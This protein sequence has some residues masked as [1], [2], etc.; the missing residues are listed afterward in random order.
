MLFFMIKYV[1]SDMLDTLLDN[2][3][4]CDSVFVTMTRVPN[5]CHY[6]LHH[7]HLY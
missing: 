3:N 2:L 4:T 5:Y 7:L 6:L 1:S